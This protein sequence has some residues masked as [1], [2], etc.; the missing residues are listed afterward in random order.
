MTPRAV[1]F[2]LLP[3]PLKVAIALFVLHFTLYAG[4]LLIS[5]AGGQ[6]PQLV[7]MI[8]TF[9]CLYMANQIRRPTKGVLF[10]LVGYCAVISALI[11]RNE[12]L[13]SAGGDDFQAVMVVA[14]FVCA[15]LFV[16][17]IFILLGRRFYMPVE[18]VRS[19]LQ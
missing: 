12:Y 16:A 10:T 5:V 19:S 3:G 14:T 18:P 9:A 15:P 17:G 13:A 2:R 6:R 1:S 8:H 7:W 4:S 11:I